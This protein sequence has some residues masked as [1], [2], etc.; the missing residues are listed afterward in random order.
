MTAKPLT[1]PAEDEKRQLQRACDDLVLEFRE[2]LAEEQVQARFQDVLRRF[3]GAPVRT[4]V[5]VLAGRAAREDLRRLA[6]A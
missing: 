2:R 1:D 4:F 6:T 3:D 5:P